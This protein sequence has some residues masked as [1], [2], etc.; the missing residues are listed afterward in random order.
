MTEEY[1]ALLRNRNWSLVPTSLSM[2]VIGCRWV[3]KIKRN[4]DGTIEHYKVVVVL[5]VESK[6]TTT[7]SNFRQVYLSIVWI[8]GSSYNVEPK[9][10][11]PSTLTHFFSI[12]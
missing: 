3:Y 11:R 6:L 10:T 9:G 4:A 12:V 8:E 2:N 1:T 5:N 7:L